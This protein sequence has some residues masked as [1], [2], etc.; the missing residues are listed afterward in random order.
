MHI[1]FIA[2]VLRRISHQTLSEHAASAVRDNGR[3]KWR[4]PWGSRRSD[5]GEPQEL[6]QRA[7]R[8]TGQP[9]AVPL[10]A[11]VTET[12]VMAPQVAQI[13]CSKMV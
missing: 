2:G 7:A 5:Q 4:L 1:M 6:P 10:A 9:V 12:R 8:G 13:W 3:G 11:A